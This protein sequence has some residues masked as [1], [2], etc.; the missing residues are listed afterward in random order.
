METFINYISQH[1]LE[2][3]ILI[4]ILFISIS[5]RVGK[6]IIKFLIKHKQVDRPDERKLHTHETPSSGGL[7]FILAFIIIIPL[8][9]NNAISIT[10]ITLSYL[11][12]ITGYIDDRYDLSA[13]IKFIIQFLAAIII[14]TQLGPIA[15]FSPH[16]NSLNYII[17][18]LFIVGFTNAFNLM[19]GIDGLAGC[20]ALLVL[21]IYAIVFVLQENYQWA[22]YTFT[23]SS[24]LIGFLY[25]NL[26]NA[27]IFMG[28]TGSLFLG[29]TISYLSLILINTNSDSVNIFANNSNFLLILGI[30]FIPMIDTIRVMFQRISKGHSPFKADRTH[31]H[32]YLL[33]LGLGTLKSTLLIV[34]ISTLFLLETYVLILNNTSV[35]QIVS[36]LLLSAFLFFNTLIFIRLRQHI[37]KRLV[38]KNYIKNIYN[39]KKLLIKQQELLA[40]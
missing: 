32:H 28:D 38:Y 22:L 14:I 9:I 24:I 18:F 8:F 11:L 4:S 16:L 40:I 2:T 25:Y 36:A 27:K 39:S 21:S 33:K 7:L 12:L 15:I 10:C 19:D 17:T 23:L 26:K 20:F 13:K 3:A 1:F 31:L 30:L 37:K 5:I 6:I 34:V 35:F 29:F